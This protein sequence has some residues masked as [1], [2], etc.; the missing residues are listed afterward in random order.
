MYSKFDKSNTLAVLDYVFSR[1][2]RLSAVVLPFLSEEMYQGMKDYLGLDALSVHHLK[3][4]NHDEKLINKKLE[5]DMNYARE[6]TTAILNARDRS[7]ITLRWP[8]SK[9]SVVSNKE[10][11][12]ACERLK[13]MILG[14]TNTKELL[15]LDAHPKYV[16]MDVKVNA[17]SMKSR[18]GD[19]IAPAIAAVTKIGAVSL[20]NELDNKG[21]VGIQVRGKKLTLTHNDLRFSVSVPEN[22][23][24]SEITSGYIYLSKDVSEAL[25][26]EGYS[27]ELIRRIQGMRKELKLRRHQDV[28]VF[29]E[30]AKSMERRLGPF[31]DDIELR[32]SCKL[33]FEDAHGDLVKEFKIRGLGFKVGM[34]K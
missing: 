11:R 9:V 2:L 34:K 21:A 19:D 16:K 31:V 26:S 1:L 30:T 33:G 12:Q 22:V 3:W 14:Q 15:L 18:L 6:V 25:L 24:A 17:E 4:P 32:C 29:I 28:D 10:V 20:K 5:S 23:V 13:E 7:G 27:R 8:V